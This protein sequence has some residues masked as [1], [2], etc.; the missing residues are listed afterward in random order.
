M[1]IRQSSPSLI[2]KF[3]AYLE[4]QTI[5]KNDVVN[6]STIILSRVFCFRNICA[7]ICSAMTREMMRGENIK[8]NNR[9]STSQFCIHFYNGTKLNIGSMFTLFELLWKMINSHSVNRYQLYFNWMTSSNILLRYETQFLNVGT[10]CITKRS[11]V[12]ANN[13]K[14]TRE[15][16]VVSVVISSGLFL[17]FEQANW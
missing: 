4:L 9:G 3:L 11:S 8:L 1:I 7:A 6:R 15:I 10:V 17:R 13:C 14:T 5:S 2:T 12:N 16:K